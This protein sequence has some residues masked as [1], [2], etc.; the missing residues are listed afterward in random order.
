MP[1][2]GNVG[3]DSRPRPNLLIASR[4]GENL[5]GDPST[6]M[7]QVDLL[8]VMIHESQALLG[9]GPDCSVIPFL[10]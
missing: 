9:T 6:A 8:P 1:G 4:R 2:L 10:V 7:G 3:S 5:A